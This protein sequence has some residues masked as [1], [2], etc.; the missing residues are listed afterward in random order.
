MLIETKQSVRRMMHMVIM[1][2]LLTDRLMWRL[3]VTH[4]QLLDTQRTINEA[5]RLLN[6]LRHASRRCRLYLVPTYVYDAAE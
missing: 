3:W 1:I 5:E 6:Q 2:H 4:Q